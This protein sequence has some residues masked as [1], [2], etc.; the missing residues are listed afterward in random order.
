MLPRGQLRIAAVLLFSL[1]AT[2]VFAGDAASDRPDRPDVR[3]ST[4]A[5]RTLEP[6]Y[7]IQAGIDG[8]IYPVFANYAS[9][10]R[11]SDRTFGVVSVTISNPSD[12]LIRRSVSVKIPGWSD[13]EIQTVEVA[14][15]AVRT[16]VFAPAFLPRLYQNH[17]I[18]AATARI[19]ITD[20]ASA[21][22]YETT[23][24]VRLRSA[25]DMFWGKGFKYASFIASWVTPH[26]REVESLLVRAKQFT[27]DRRLPGYEDWKNPEEQEQA[28]YRQAKAIF[29]ALQRSGFSYVKSSLTLGDHKGVSERV[30]MPRVSL[31][32]SSANCIDAAVMYASLFENLG[33]DATVVIVPGHA[34][35]G[36]RVAEGSSKF[37]MIDAALTGRTTFA[38]AVASA[39]DGLARHAPSTVTQVIVE[40][41]RSAGIFPMP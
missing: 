8:E 31:S 29:T 20:P 30:R 4:A 38:E 32:Q 18:V 6:T 27:S 34:Y 19:Y 9:L 26:D 17:E 10:Q 2:L 14:A 40:Q 15:G 1:L 36:V 22:V 12:V 3:T 23:Q 5:K 25:E 11:Q 24:P 41:A 28:T 37:L 33:M 35:A 16:L 21:N 39:E 7:K 13:E